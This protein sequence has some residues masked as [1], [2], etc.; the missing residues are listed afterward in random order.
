M[1][2]R[3][4]II[5]HPGGENRRFNILSDASRV[6]EPNQPLREFFSVHLASS[7][8]FTHVKGKLHAEGDRIS[9][10]NPAVAVFRLNGM[11]E[12]M[13]EIQ[14]SSYPS[15]FS[16]SRTTADLIEIPL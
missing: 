3:V 1:P 12:R 4:F 10:C 6:A 13:A 5:H 11:A 7:N 16:S 15:S 14:K 2:P 8:L 9:M